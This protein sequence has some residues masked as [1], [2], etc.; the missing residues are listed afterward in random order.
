MQEVIVKLREEAPKMET[1]SE[2]VNAEFMR[3]KGLCLDL[4]MAASDEGR[5]ILRKALYGAMTDFETQYAK[6]QDSVRAVCAVNASYK[7]KLGV[8][9]RR[10]SKDAP[11]Q[12]MLDLGDQVTSGQST[13]DTLNTPDAPDASAAA[14]AP[15]TST[16]LPANVAAQGFDTHGGGTAVG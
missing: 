13:S 9:R 6:L 5:A 1:L 15:T 7:E 10:K 8:T 4:E 14:S 11:G 3:A 16:A 12:Q 2:T